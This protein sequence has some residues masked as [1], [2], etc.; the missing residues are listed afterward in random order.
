MHLLKTLKTYQNCLFDK[1]KLPANS[2]INHYRSFTN[3]LDL[4]EALVTEESVF[5]LPG[6]CFN[7]ANFFRIVLTVPENLLSEACQRIANFCQKHYDFR[8]RFEAIQT[9]REAEETSSG[10]SNGSSDENEDIP[11]ISELKLAQFTQMA[12]ERD[13]TPSRLA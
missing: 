2:F 11:K 4:V 3:D 13:G 12:S 10:F 9:L 7:I 1:K 6:K 8:A 5:C